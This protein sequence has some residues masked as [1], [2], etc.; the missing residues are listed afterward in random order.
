VECRGA[1]TLPGQ[2]AGAIAEI[3]KILTP[4]RRLTEQVD[5]ERLRQHLID[6]NEWCYKHRSQTQVSVAS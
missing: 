5:L 2:D 3:V 4:I 6:M 1:P